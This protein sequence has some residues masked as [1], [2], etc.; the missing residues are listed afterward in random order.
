MNEYIEADVLQL[1]LSSPE[2]CEINIVD[3]D[4]GRS[5]HLILIHSSIL[6]V[7]IHILIIAN[8]TVSVRKD[9]QFN[10]HMPLTY[11][12]FPPIVRYISSVRASTSIPLDESGIV[13]LNILSLDNWS[14][15]IYIYI[16]T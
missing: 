12:D 2:E 9:Y 1:L 11:P 15:W 10:V 5:H 4:Y 7:Q 13:L 3:G 14:R 16:T 8:W 6:T